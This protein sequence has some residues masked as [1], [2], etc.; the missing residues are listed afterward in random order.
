MVWK[1][2]LEI[3]GIQVFIASSESVTYSRGRWILEPLLVY[4]D[5]IDVEDL[6]T[7]IP[8]ATAYYLQVA[9][10]VTILYRL[11]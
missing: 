6:A 7:L 4:I 10:L 2:V 9:P 3:T 1:T 5:G 11:I 8:M